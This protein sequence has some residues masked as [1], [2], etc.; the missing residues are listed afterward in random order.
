LIA[1]AT[2]MG[3]VGT[4]FASAGGTARS[5][6]DVPV[7]G[8]SFVCVCVCVC[9]CG[10]VPFNDQLQQP[11]QIGRDLCVDWKHND[12]R[13][14]LLHPAAWFSLPLPH[15]QIKIE[16]L[17]LFI[18]FLFFDSAP[19]FS[20]SIECVIAAWGVGKSVKSLVRLL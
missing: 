11:R 10:R 20:A 8:N 15:K 1:F 4:V 7:P 14:F 9:V 18:F 19:H 17:L 2:G 5:G 6:F 3:R 16:Y 12:V 13:L